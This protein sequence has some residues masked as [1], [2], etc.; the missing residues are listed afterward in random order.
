MKVNVNRMQHW[1]LYGDLQESSLNRS[2]RSPTHTLGLLTL[3]IN[4]LIITS[5]LPTKF[6]VIGLFAVVTDSWH[7]VTL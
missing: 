1:H 3:L 5:L 2:L 6:R 4:V 7:I